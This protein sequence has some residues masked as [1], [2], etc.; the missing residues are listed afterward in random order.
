MTDC[1]TLSRHPTGLWVLSMTETWERF[2]Y[3]GVRALLVLYLT[4]GALDTERFERVYGSEVA[5][6]IFGRPH[7]ESAEAQR[8]AFQ[9]CST[10]STL[11]RAFHPSPRGSPSCMYGFA[12]ID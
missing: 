6:M 9:V 4:N 10:H 2:S 11:L 3:Y 1:A 12:L 8:L 5:Y 7:G